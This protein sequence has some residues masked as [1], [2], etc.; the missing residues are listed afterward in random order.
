[1]HELVETWT[2]STR[3]AV[4]HCSWYDVATLWNC[5]LFLCNKTN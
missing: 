2:D 1:L 4:I 5:Y 3:N